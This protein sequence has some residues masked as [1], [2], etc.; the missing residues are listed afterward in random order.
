MNI[1]QRIKHSTKKRGKRHPLLRHYK[2]ETSAMEKIAADID[3]EQEE[4]RK[5][6]RVPEDWIS[7][8][9]YWK[10]DIKK[11]ITEKLIQEK[12]IEMIEIISK[13]KILE[14]MSFIRSLVEE[15]HGRSKD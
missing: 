14:A 6:E 2:E 10:T 9:P 11:K 3:A 1:T 15:I 5:E 7:G 4:E 13:G 8:E 12:T